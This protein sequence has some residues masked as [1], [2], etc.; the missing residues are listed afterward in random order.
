MENNNNLPLV[1]LCEAEMCI[2]DQAKCAL[3]KLQSATY[4]S[5]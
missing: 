5:L 2:L 4:H 1:G 3:W